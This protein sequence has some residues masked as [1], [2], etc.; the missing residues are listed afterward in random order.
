MAKRLPFS[1]KDGMTVREFIKKADSIIHGKTFSH[2]HKAL[3][4]FIGLRA[5]RGS[6]DNVSKFINAYDLIHNTVSSIAPSENV[7]VAKVSTDPITQKFHELEREGCFL[8]E[9]EFHDQLLKG[10]NH[11]YSFLVAP[12]NHNPEKRA[13]WCHEP[14][15]SEV[16]FYWI[17]E[18]DGAKSHVFSRSPEN[19][20]ACLDYI[21]DLCWEPF[22]GF[23]EIM[24]NSSTGEFH[25]KS[26]S[27]LPWDYEGEQGD[28]LI[29]RWKKFY[30]HKT[31]RSVILHGKPG[32]GKST[33]A[34]HAARHVGSRVCMINVATM[35]NLSVYDV[36]ELL[37]LLGPDVFIVDDLDRLADNDL[38]LLLSFFEES[39]NAIPLLIATTNHLNQLPQAMRRPGRFDEIWSVAPPKGEVRKRVILY[40]AE[41]EKA[42]LSE[43]AVER[44]LE[45]AESQDLPGAHLRELVRRVGLLGLSELDFDSNDLTFS[46]DWNVE[47]L[48]EFKIGSHPSKPS[49]V[50]EDVGYVRGSCE[51]S[52][53]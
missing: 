24:F 13:V 33:L 43:E 4:A 11:E 52:Y 49:L 8:M 36:L 44:I 47:D 21:R 50:K 35:A 9:A 40:L 37:E 51:E 27:G 15:D 5:L 39:H 7:K 2:G 1:S 6:K 45:I 10:L 28:H 30:D 16:A 26:K 31:R 42:E 12:E 3:A 29:E 48:S 22:E 38:N 14:P 46:E 25:F 53:E 18:S 23:V 19:A 41:L 17:E 32:T 20:E 34:Q